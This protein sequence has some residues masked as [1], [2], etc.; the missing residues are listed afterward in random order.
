MRKVFLGF[1]LIVL[2]VAAQSGVAQAK[3][4]DCSY[5]VVGRTY[6]H[7]FGGFVNF[8]TIVPNAGAGYF[9]FLPHNVVKSSTTLMIGKA[10][11]LKDMPETGTYSLAWNTSTSPAVC[12]GTLNSGE[13]AF[14]IVVAQGGESIE[15][16][17]ADANGLV[18]GFTASP[19]HEPNC[20]LQTIKGTYTYNAKGWIVPPFPLPVLSDF[21]NFTPFGFSGAIHFDGAGNLNGWDTVSLN[22]AIMQRTYTGTYTMS[23][24][25]V[26]EMVLTDTMGNTITTQNLVLKDGAAI[27]AVNTDQTLSTALAFTSVRTGS[28]ECRRDE[29]R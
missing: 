13:N 22:G 21:F 6:A 2:I 29:R 19:M 27:H 8:G 12:T 1:L 24:G 11:L 26:S 4:G 7:Q 28:A 23:A 5:L 25:C 16:F 3:S 14:Q 18:V 9:Q 17:H 10:A 15:F 20:S